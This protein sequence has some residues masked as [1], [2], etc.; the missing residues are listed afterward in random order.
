[1]AASSSRP[2]SCSR[3]L[4]KS[5]SE[6][7]ST[8]VR[9]WLSS[10]AAAPASSETTATF[11]ASSSRSRVFRSS[12]SRRSSSLRSRN[13]PTVAVSRPS[14]VTMAADRSTGIT[15]PLLA[16]TSQRTRPNSSPAVRASRSLRIISSASP[17]G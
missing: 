15:S 1:M 5:S 9:G 7:P 4:R 10:C 11:S 17:G 3:V 14:S 8:L 13:T 6:N 12:D 2:L 16:T